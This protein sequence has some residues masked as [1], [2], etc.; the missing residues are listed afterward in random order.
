MHPLDQLLQLFCPFDCLVCGREADLICPACL[1]RLPTPPGRCYR[2]RQPGPAL[3]A[4]C[5]PATGLHTVQVVTDYRD[6]AAPL[7]HA[8]KFARA[9]AAAKIVAQAMHQRLPAFP[10]ETIICHLPTAN[11]R[12]RQR[13]YDQAHLIARQLARLR[14]LPHQTLLRRQGSARQLGANRNQRLAQLQTAFYCPRPLAVQRRTILLVDD[15]LTTG[16]SLESASRVLLQA[17][18]AYVQAATFAQKL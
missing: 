2:C 12:V 16:A 14:G 10:P 7:L 5:Q 17:G 4:V 3:C 1:P 9:Q 8:L 13:G 11:V 15:V 18:A 6:P